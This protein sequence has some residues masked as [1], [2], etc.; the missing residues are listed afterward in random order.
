MLFMP[1]IAAAMVKPGA[2]S[3]IRSAAAEVPIHSRSAA[4]S[5]LKGTGERLPIDVQQ[6]FSPRLGHDFSK[7]RMHYDPNAARLAE[8]LD[9]RAFTVGEDIAFASGEYRPGAFA[10]RQLIAH[11]LAHVV[12]QNRYGNSALRCGH[13]W[14]G[15]SEA[16]PAPV[17]RS[18]AGP[19]NHISPY[20][21]DQIRP[22]P[23]LDWSSVL[24]HT[25]RHAQASA[26][27]I[28]AKAYT[29]ANHI[30][31][32][33]Y[34]PSRPAG[35][36][37]IAHELGH[38]GAG[39]GSD[40]IHLAADPHLRDYLLR[41]R[42]V[43]GDPTLPK[44]SEG[45]VARIFESLNGLDLSDKDNFTFIAE[46]VAEVFPEHVALGF[47]FEAQSRFPMVRTAPPS[48]AQQQYE[49][50]LRQIEAIPRHGPY[51]TRAPGV[52]FPL[53]PAALPKIDVPVALRNAAAGAYTFIAGVWG[54]LKES[55][56][57]D[58]LI[59][60]A[61]RL[62][63]AVALTVIFP[64]I[65]AAGAVVGVKNDIVSLFEAIKGLF[66]GG[67]GDLLASVDEVVGILVSEDAGPFGLRAGLEFG[68]AFGHDLV[69]ASQMG[70]VEF[71]YT[72][73]RLVG[74]TII[75]T[76]LTLVGFPEFIGAAI[77]TRLAEVLGPLLE[78][79]PRLARLLEKLVA[80]MTR[81]P[82]RRPMLGPA[83]ER[84]AT[85]KTVVSEA[86][87]A[88]GAAAQKPAAGRPLGPPPGP[89]PRIRSV[90]WQDLAE[91][92]QLELLQ[93]EEV[94]GGAT[95][96]GKDVQAGGHVLSGHVYASDRVLEARALASDAPITKFA[97]A[98]T[99]VNA[100]NQTLEA[101]AKEVQSFTSNL[102][103][104]VPASRAF[105]WT[106][107]ASEPAAGY[108]F[109]RLPNGTVQRISGLR[110]VIVVLQ[111][112]GTLGWVIRTAFPAL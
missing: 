25:D 11:E 109:Q 18:L 35:R 36:Q 55:V 70:I 76:I 82:R 41:L 79:E 72:L 54:G 66:T 98:D 32:G 103:P 51:G 27:V 108:G 23:G 105:E 45:I 2:S 20:L 53:L 57:G 5:A 56:T 10:G 16:V 9:A 49:R 26:H 3:S 111:S 52:L 60:L 95:R 86:E 6:F 68:R 69:E 84:A 14:A 75:Y 78:N 87:K 31:F 21:L 104:G 102:R 65:F 19:G 7:V 81:P 91:W 99:A 12:Q 47:L 85:E 43:A 93:P 74:P 73:G 40:Q 97:D 48:T 101:N 107:P 94:A 15:G 89:L 29:V 28:G 64:P 100:I 62:N 92:E 13:V 71:T 110:K 67:L 46:R 30:V 90:T 58:D 77:G 17:R 4:Q 106:V 42:Q 33:Q 96:V 8:S 50:T 63:K 22:V 37:L 44:K 1:V 83:G 24:V 80:R 112:H 88:A 39:A 38:L 59:K 34:Q 61:D